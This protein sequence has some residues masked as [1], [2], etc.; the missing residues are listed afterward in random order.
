LPAGGG[1]RR[2]RE[3][4]SV[5]VVAEAAQRVL[6]R[7][8]PRVVGSLGMAVRYISAA[9]DARIGGDLYEVVATPRGVRVIVGDVQDT[10]RAAMETAA[11]VVGVFREAAHDAQDLVAVAARL[12]AT[13]A[14]AGG[15]EEFVTAILIE[16]HPG[17]DEIEMLNC[18]HP[19]PLVLGDGASRFAEPDEYG[20]PLG[21]TALADPG[22]HT[23]KLSFAANHRILL[24]T[25]GISEARDRDGRFYPLDERARLFTERDLEAALDELKV[26]VLRHV[27]GSLDDDAAMLLLHR[28]THR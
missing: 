28:R 17:V 16:I 14:R 24:Y 5:R 4:A 26:D 25:D 7:P 19:P 1:Q 15:A 6:L 3:L 22:R 23:H 21:L 18:G 9:A 11:T 10:G 8:V 13:L 2:E 20:P 12:E 27:G